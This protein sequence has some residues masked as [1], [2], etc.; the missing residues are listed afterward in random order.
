VYFAKGLQDSGMRIYKLNPAVDNTVLVNI[1]RQVVANFVNVDSN[2]F[3][4]VADAS[5]KML[6]SAT[7]GS[8]Q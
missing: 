5:V 7:P 4:Q 2:S 6:A 1:N 3:G 8:G